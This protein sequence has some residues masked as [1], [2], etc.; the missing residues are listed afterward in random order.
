MLV[1]S[2]RTALER[3]RTK[4][5]R[6]IAEHNLDVPTPDPEM[7]NAAIPVKEW[8]IGKLTGKPEAPW[9]TIYIVVMINTVT[10]AIYCY[11]NH[12]FGALLMWEQLTERIAVTQMLNGG[13]CAWPVVRLEQR[14]W[15]SNTFGAQIRPHL[16]PIDWRIIGNGEQPESRL[17]APTSP[18]APA[19]A[20][21]AS[22]TP[23]PTA[24]SAPATA[25][26][27]PTTSSSTPLAAAASARSSSPILDH[28]QSVKPITVG[29]MIAD[30]IPWK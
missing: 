29:E 13:K 25:P 24:A 28:M 5:D 26:A 7:L 12:T 10:G 6:N 14:P 9:K 20:A 4:D 15:T 11:K 3:W 17:S 18:A 21:P 16:E 19:L 1:V 27:A 8:R 22:H 30:E 2:Y 23:A